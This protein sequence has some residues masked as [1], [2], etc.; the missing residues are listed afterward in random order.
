M[1]S[2]LP[3]LH[4]PYAFLLSD[5]LATGF[6]VTTNCAFSVK[7][8][9]NFK[10]RSDHL[11]SGA[12]PPTP[13]PCQPHGCRMSGSRSEQEKQNEQMEKT[14]QENRVRSRTQLRAG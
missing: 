8:L 4:T 12:C 6:K 1:H 11:L 3:T 5:F 7:I 2:C 9:E 13:R 14:E 10:L